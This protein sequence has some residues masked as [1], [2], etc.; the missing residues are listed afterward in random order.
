LE[1]WTV[2]RTG[3]HVSKSYFIYSRQGIKAPRCLIADKLYT[4]ESW[5]IWRK[6]N[7]KK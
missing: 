5:V 7:Y 1:Y 3:A 6:R 2:V 4:F